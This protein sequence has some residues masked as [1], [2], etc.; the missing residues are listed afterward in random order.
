MPQKYVTIRF[1]FM[2]AALLGLA[3]GVIDLFVVA[4]SIPDV[5]RSC[6]VIFVCMLI[7]LISTEENL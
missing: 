1:F 3:I 2:L 6:T 5:I 7:G 4:K